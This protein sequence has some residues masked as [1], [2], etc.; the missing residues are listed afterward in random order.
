MGS[1]VKSVVRGVSDGAD[2]VS[3]TMGDVLD[4]V[5]ARVDD[6]VVMA[7]PRK[8]EV[9]WRRRGGL[10]LVVVVLVAGAVLVRKRKLRTSTTGAHGSATSDGSAA[11]SRAEVRTASGNDRHDT[12]V[13][14]DAGSSASAKSAKSAKLAKSAKSATSGTFAAAAQSPANSKH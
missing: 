4:D 11:D 13:S 14:E 5:K 3:H 12:T 7:H 10:L 9:R 6:M 2:A 1:M 8:A